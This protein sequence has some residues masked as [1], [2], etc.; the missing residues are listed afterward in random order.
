M[1]D[2]VDPRT[3]HKEHTHPGA[4]IYF[5]VA[6]AL[7]V[8]TALEVSAFE[9]ARRP[10][11]LRPLVEPVVVPILLVLSAVKFGLVAMFYMHL[12]QDARIY[13]GLFVFPLIIAAVVILSL[14][15][16]LQYWRIA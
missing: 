15:L 7:F 8:L 13:R 4:A 12:K 9:V 3:A 10:G 6:V 5:R 16:L 1:S 14:I 2:L 11:T